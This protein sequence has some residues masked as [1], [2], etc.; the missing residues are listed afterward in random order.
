MT[1][2]GQERWSITGWYHDDELLKRQHTQREK[3]PFHGQP[4]IMEDKIEL[5]D[6]INPQYI[7]Y[8]GVRACSSTVLIGWPASLLDACVDKIDDRLLLRCNYL[9]TV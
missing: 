6:W 8:L 9:V 5:K 4:P 7:R 1:A 3:P 2:E